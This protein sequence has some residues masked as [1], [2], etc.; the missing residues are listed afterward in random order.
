M[1]ESLGGLSGRSLDDRKDELRL[2]EIEKGRK[3]V[4]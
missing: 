4:N 1:D 2:R 3:R